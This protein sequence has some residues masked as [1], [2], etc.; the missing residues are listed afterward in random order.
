VSATPRTRVALTIKECGGG[1]ILFYGKKKCSLPLLQPATLSLSNFSRMVIHFMLIFRSLI[2]TLSFY[3]TALILILLTLPFYFLL[4]R[5]R[6]WG[7]ARFWIKCSLWLAK[8]IAGIDYQIEGK[9]HIPQGA[10]IIA[11]KHQ[12]AWETMALLLHFADPVLILKREL[13]FIPLFGWY[14]AKVGVIAI[15]RGA[16]IQAMKAVIKGAKEKAA[17]SRQILIFPEGTRRIPGDEPDYKPGIAALY[18]ELDLPVVIV[19]HNAGLY[20]PRNN[21]R[22]YPGTIQV[23]ILPPLLPGLKRRDFLPLLA[24]QT[25]QACDDLLRIAANTAQ[26]P[27][28]PAPALKRL[29][30][31]DQITADEHHENI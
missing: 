13:M 6:A 1:K 7:V 2:Y 28:L 15:N 17:L 14:M 23:R 3:A 4:P 16:P 12:S 22:R 19:A 20:W 31:L 27:A 26:P 29:K 10:C 11:A 21:F 24:Q 9:E 30:E 25:E 8:H 5:M 18:G